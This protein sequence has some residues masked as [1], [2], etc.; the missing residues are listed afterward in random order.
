MTKIRPKKASSP[1]GA[2]FTRGAMKIEGAIHG[3]RGKHRLERQS[4]QG[5]GFYKDNVVNGIIMLVGRR[6]W[7]DKRKIS[8]CLRHL[9]H[10][11]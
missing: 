9:R 8:H 2:K 4:N 11:L 7:T 10:L 6:D 5:D 3:L 1:S